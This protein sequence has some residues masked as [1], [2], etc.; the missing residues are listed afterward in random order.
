MRKI[1]SAALL[2]SAFALSPATPAFAVDEINTVPGLTAAGGPLAL[3]GYDP[4]G[5]FTDGKPQLGDAKF[6]ATHGGAAY[7]FANRANL[8]A[9][10]ADPAKYVPQYGGYCAYGVAVGK[11]FDGDPRFWK[12]VDGKL[13]VN[14]NAD[15]AA[16]F[17]ADVAG[18]IQKAE[19]NWT[20]IKSK[21][22]ADL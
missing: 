21:A 20:E 4:V 9:F 11:K 22:P 14:L 13:Y 17:D 8:E 5:F 15:I 7:Y 6:T 19:T 16:K 18:A 12:I 1:I 2:V 3:H 10:E